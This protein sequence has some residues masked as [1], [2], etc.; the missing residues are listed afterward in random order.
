MDLADKTDEEVVVLVRS[1]DSDSFGIVIARYEERMLRYARRFLLDT[2]DAKDLA[3]EVFI[4][5]YANL[6][7]F[8]AARKF[9][10]WLYRIAHNEFLNFIKRKNGRQVFSLFDVDTLFPHPIAK[11]TAD[12]GIGL[13]E[14]KEWLEKS[15]STLDAKYREPI[16]LYY[17]EEMDYREIADILEIPVSTVGVR[18]A[19]GREMLKKQPR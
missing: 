13:R 12:Q 8:D 4:K 10:S 19:R 18:L 17:L 11:E 7:S 5:A 6:Q 15:L 16:I 3:Q 1:G 2:E 9:S 14:N